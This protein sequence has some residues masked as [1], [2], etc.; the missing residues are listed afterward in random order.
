MIGDINELVLIHHH[1]DMKPDDEF[2]FFQRWFLTCLHR[3]KMGKKI[4]GYF[5]TDGL[6]DF[7]LRLDVIIKTCCFHAY[8]FSQVPHGRSPKA[9]FAKK[10]GCLLNDC[11]FFTAVLFTPDLGHATQR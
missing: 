6:Q 11:V 4:V 9:L 1:A 10:L 5:K 7:G 2:Q 8:V 3:F